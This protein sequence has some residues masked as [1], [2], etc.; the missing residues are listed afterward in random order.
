MGNRLKKYAF[1]ILLFF[2]T[3][4]QASTYMLSSFICH[5]FHPALFIHFCFYKDKAEEY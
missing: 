1:F 2:D 5:F 3:S 4:L